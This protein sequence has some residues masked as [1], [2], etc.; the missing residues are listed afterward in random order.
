MIASA[1][2][3]GWAGGKPI[4]VDVEKERGT[5]DSEEIKKKITSKTI[6]IMPVHIL[7]RS[8]DMK[9]LQEIAQEHNLTIIEDAAGALGS[10]HD[11]R[12]LGTFGK[13]G[14]FSLQSNKIIR[15]GHGGIV[16]TN[17]NRYYEMIKR[18]RNFGRMSNKE[19]L[20]KIE[21]Y[22]LKFNDLSAALALSQFRKIQQ[23]RERLIE[24]KKLYEKELKGINKIE[25]P[26]TKYENGE[27]PLYVDAIVEERNKLIVCLE[28]NY[29]FG[30]KCLPPLHRN[31]PYQNQG[32]DKMFPNSC[33]V[34]DNCLWLH[35]CFNI[36][37]QDIEKTC[38]KIRKFYGKN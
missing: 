21:G 14:C 38:E 2:A 20:H 11:G 35:N 24:Q 34:S 19:F 1:A 10:K 32:S 23:R 13:I 26:V 12:F 36:S 30:I 16:V 5:I 28:S 37:K 8:V 7:G 6:A 15:S 22:N 4:L 29:I 25:I 3:V 9:K 17:D 33:S 18:L 31:P 27:I